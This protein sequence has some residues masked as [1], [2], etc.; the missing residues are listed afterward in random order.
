MGLKPQCLLSDLLRK[1]LPCILSVLLLSSCQWDGEYAPG[2]RGPQGPQG[3]ANPNGVQG[4]QGPAGD[5]GATGP[6]GP[7]CFG[8][9]CG[10]D[11]SITGVITHSGRALFTAVPT[12]S[13]IGDGPM[14]I[15]PTTAAATETILGV[16]ENGTERLQINKEGRFALS[17][18]NNGLMALLT[19]NSSA[20]NANETILGIAN[21][22]TGV[23][24]I[25]RE[26]DTFISGT[27][28]LGNTLTT[29]GSTTTLAGDDGYLI[30][31][32]TSA[33]NLTLDDT[34]IQARNNGA[35]S[36]LY[37][38]PLGGNFEFNNALFT[39]TV[40]IPGTV[41]MGCE[42]VFLTYRNTTNFSPGV[43]AA[44]TVPFNSESFDVGS[45]YNT[46]TGEFVAPCDGLYHFASTVF[47]DNTNGS[48]EIYS[49]WIYV[50]G[51]AYVRL[52]V[53]EDTIGGVNF[54][55]GSV[56]ADLSQGDVVT[57]R[58]QAT[59]DTDH[60]IVSSATLQSFFTGFKYFY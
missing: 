45:N 31:G 17:G 12:G 6:A 24:R 29:T 60:E 41:T 25:D 8:S 55:N 13:G 35:A 42:A 19:L 48:N 4:V 39:D 10:G 37:L 3:P 54:L 15:N 36:T 40:T 59:L 52:A 7:V 33:A 5:V 34:N 18:F 32:Q 50:N 22:G 9:T 30:L 51:T 11:T 47:L 53:I 49:L 20:S 56:L 14:Y 23:F 58:V 57:V 46:A 28:T 21:N 44:T 2:S 16:A 1:K 27:L 43:S 38:N 26:G